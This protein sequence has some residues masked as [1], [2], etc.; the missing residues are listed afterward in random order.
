MKKKVI[1]SS[2]AVYLAEYIQ[3]LGIDVHTDYC[4]LSVDKRI[5]DHADI[6]YFFDTQDTLFVAESVKETCGIFSNV[7]GDLVVVQDKQSE[8]YPYDV[9][10]NCVAV[11]KYFIC[12]VNT[13][14]AQILK[15]MK[16]LGF[17]IIN[18]KQGYTKCSVLPVTD[19]AIITDDP[20]VCDAC[21]MHN[22]DTLLV[23]K[24]NVNLQGFPY[25][26]IGGVGGKIS[27]NLILFNGDIRKHFDYKKIEMFLAKYNVDWVCAEGVLIDIGSILPL[28]KV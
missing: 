15:H 4:N 14:S 28:Y 5:S 21:I 20:S 12:N 2:S 26:F 6:S 11:G 1:L 18:V 9:Q 17:K 24:G 8:N 3:S 22:I 27:D 25:G 23:S 16:N 7:C 10:L 19:N 13:V